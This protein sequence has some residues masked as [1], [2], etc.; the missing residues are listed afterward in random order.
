VN[1]LE[2]AEMVCGMAAA[3][4]PVR[5]A[6]AAVTK[7]PE[8]LKGV[9][10]EAFSKKYAQW[11]ASPLLRKMEVRSVRIGMFNN[12]LANAVML[13]DPPEA[14][15]VDI[16]GLHSQAREQPARLPA[17]FKAAAPYGDFKE[18]EAEAAVLFPKLF[19]AAA[20]KCPEGTSE[21]S[22]ASHG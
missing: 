7:G 13:L 16:A 19:E 18:L 21:G 2:A 4:E 9:T 11:E 8:G 3:G 17:L 10:L 12:K 1:E 14:E 6:F 15:A 5:K 22:E 20:P